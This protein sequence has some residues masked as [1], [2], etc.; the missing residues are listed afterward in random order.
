MEQLIN[1][2]DKICQ[3]YASKDAIL[4]KKGNISYSELEKLINTIRQT[5]SDAGLKPRQTIA[6]EGI[7]IIEFVAAY[8]AAAKLNICIVPIDVR[9]SEK[10]IAIILKDSQPSAYIVSDKNSS[11]SSIYAHT[12]NNND[13]A[14]INIQGHITNVDIIIDPEPKNNVNIQDGDLVIQYSSGSTGKPKGVVLSRDNIYH[15]VT[16]WNTSLGI[17]ETDVFLNTLTLCHC[18]GMY[19]HTMS[20]LLA[21]AQVY[22]PDL[23]AITPSHIAKIIDEQNVTVFGTLPYMYQMLLMLPEDRLKLDRV[24]YLI[25]GSAPLPAVI[26]KKFHE[27]FGHHINQVYGLTEIGLITFN[28]NPTDPNSIGTLTHNMEARIVNDIGKECQQGEAGELVVRCASMSRGYLNNPEDQSNMF[29]GG[30]LYTKDI[31]R[32]D[33]EGNFYMNGRI[34]QFINVGGN[35]VSPS[36]VENVL[37]EHP[38]INEAA[39]LG[40]RNES[41]TEDVVAF[42]VLKGDSPEVSRDEIFKYCSERLSAYKM[43]RELNF[44]DSIPKSPLGKVLKSQLCI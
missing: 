37:V 36:E 7:N 14:V 16:N 38:N 25:S 17:N 24:R 39:V 28:A 3:Q 6:I 8:F 19:V 30:W 41:T 22:M 40:K 5:L 26:A 12:K 34:S 31:V 27:K 4:S 43:P 18:Y 29:K 33:E 11:L 44:I 32:Q 20:A 23:Q 10:E 21:G 1:Q 35:K 13:T 42:V 2:F 9:L 15:K